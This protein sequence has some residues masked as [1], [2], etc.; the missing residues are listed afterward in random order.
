MIWVW[1]GANFDRFTVP[2][3]LGL[4]QSL[5]PTLADTWMNNELLKQL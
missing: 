2:T 4:D 3:L 1:L 5:V